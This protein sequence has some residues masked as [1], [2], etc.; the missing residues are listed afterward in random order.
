M[1]SLSRTFCLQMN[2]A[3]RQFFEGDMSQFSGRMM[4]TMIDKKRFSVLRQVTWVA[5]VPTRRKMGSF[6]A[7]SSSSISLTK[8]NNSSK[9]K[10]NNKRMIGKLHRIKSVAQMVKMSF[11]FLSNNRILSD[12]MFLHKGIFYKQNFVLGI[13]FSVSQICYNE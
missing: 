5:L 6:R 7:N 9:K 8:S 10:K 3:S 13:G 4:L 1:P 12:C 11:L 2:S